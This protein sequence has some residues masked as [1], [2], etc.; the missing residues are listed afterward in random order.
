VTALLSSACCWLPL[1][2]IA[3]GASAAGVSGFFETYRPYLLGATG[4]LLAGGFYLVY[5][6]KARCEPGQACAVENPRLKRFNRITLW[7]ATVLVLSFAL[8]PNYVGALLGGEDVPA[9]EDVVLSGEVREF[10]IEGMTCEA[11]AV[12]LRTG[13]SRLPGVAG[14]EVSFASGTA[15][16]SFEA[17]VAPPSDDAV[18]RAISEVGYTGTRNSESETEGKQG[19]ERS[20]GVGPGNRRN[21]L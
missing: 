10:R 21:D 16:L 17:A 1:L 11:C 14:A 12:T 20:P 5:F 6:K 13:L 9:R 19:N 7:S 3:F 8:F 2:L 18:R 15:T 4:L